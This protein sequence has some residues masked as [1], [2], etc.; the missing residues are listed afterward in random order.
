MKVA[1]GVINNLAC[2]VAVMDCIV[3]VAA[4]LAFPVTMASAVET[5]SLAI[6][7]SC[8]RSADLPPLIPDTIIIVMPNTI[9]IYTAEPIAAVRTILRVMPGANSSSF[10]P[11]S[12]FSSLFAS[13]L[14]A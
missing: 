6:F 13:A 7:V 5:R 9:R 8:A 4:I 11:C 1:D 10:L 2:A 12:I 3:W 14:R